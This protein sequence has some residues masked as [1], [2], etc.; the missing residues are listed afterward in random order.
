[1]P[2]T[3]EVLQILETV[4][5]FDGDFVFTT[6]GGRRPIH[7]PKVQKKLD[8]LMLAELRAM[9][10][11]CGDDPD[12]IVLVPWRNHD[13]RRTV[14]SNLARLRIAD[15]VAEAVLGHARPGI[16]G[17]YDLHSYRD[18]KLAALQAWS[19]LLHSIIEQKPPN[20]VALKSKKSK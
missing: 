20:V 1:M 11:Q 15:P 6:T 12:R 4:P 14:R 8:G 17:V 13:I 7:L 19:N 3:A 10:A 16:L 18:E 5:R 9:A 2:L